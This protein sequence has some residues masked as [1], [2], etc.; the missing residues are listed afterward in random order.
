MV[1]LIIFSF[2]RSCQ[3][4]LLLESLLRNLNIFNIKVLYKC[5]S[6]EFQK[7]YDQLISYFEPLGVT[8]IKEESFGID[9]RKIINNSSCDKILFAVDDDVIYR[10]CPISYTSVEDHMPKYDSEVFSF[11]LGLN[12]IMQDYSRNLLQ[13]PLNRYSECMCGEIISWNPHEYLNIYNYGYPM[14]VDMHVF[15]KSLLLN[16]FQKIKPF[17]NPNQLEGHMYEFRDMI[18]CMSSFQHSVVVNIPVNNMS[19]ITPTS[20]SFSIDFLNSQYLAGKRLDLDATM[21]YNVVGC[22]QIIPYTFIDI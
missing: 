3:A 18:S 10:E 2:N 9:V 14:S 5:S 22:H 12:T 6:P 7:G 21:R 11:R 8:F 1:D 20:N 19:G 16:I 15:R 4:H 17:N 13:P